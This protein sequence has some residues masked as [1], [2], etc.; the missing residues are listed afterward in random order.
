MSGFC[1]FD[2][3]IDGDWISSVELEEN[4]PQLYADALI[5]ANDIAWQTLRIQDQ[6]DDE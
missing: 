5:T 2:V 6:Y 3:R 4:Y 1:H